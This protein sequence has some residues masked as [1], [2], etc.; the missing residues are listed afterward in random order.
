MSSHR[1]ASPGRT[2]GCSALARLA[3]LAGIVLSLTLVGCNPGAENGAK[4]PLAFADPLPRDASLRDAL[5]HPDVLQRVERVARILDAAGPDAL[6]AMRDEF[7]QA[8]LDQGDL[9]YA[10][11]MNWWARFDPTAA[12][13]YYET[14][15]RFDHPRVI[16]EIMRVW[17]RVDPM[18]AVQAATLS[19][20][21]SAMPELRSELV[22]LLVVG[23]FES[24]NPGLEEWIISKGSSNA[25]VAGW[26][27]YA[28]ML[29]LRDGTEKAFE[30]IRNEPLPDDH[31]RLVWAGALT[32]LAR[33]Q[34]EEAVEWLA[35]AEKDGIDVGSFTARIARSWA[36]NDPEKAMEWMRG[37]PENEE[38]YRAT[39][40]VA[41]RWMKRDP[42]GFDRWIDSIQDELWSDGLRAVSF[43]NRIERAR[44]QVDWPKLLQEAKRSS[45]VSTEDGLQVWLLQRWLVVDP[46]AAEAWIQAN[47]DELS[48]DYVMRSRSITE[49]DRKKIEDALVG[50]G[51]TDAS[52]PEAAE[53]DAA[54]K[55]A[56]R[57]EANPS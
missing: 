7:E 27:A 8:P 41:K 29:L 44:Y 40:D 57:S 1:T 14:Q 32:V 19:R 13:N 10:L 21:E 48:A 54:E 43:T 38:R 15:L 45:T 55:A 37:Q 26:R 4:G 53:A 56:Q 17:G 16:L 18:A 35:V 33:N 51:R 31:R 5:R 46:P 2:R 23:W 20:L 6:D 52:A 3:A 36:V 22:D 42:E 30:W 34:P 24:K 47:P 11:F 25:A 9:E 50:I 49:K 39:W 28:R 12:H